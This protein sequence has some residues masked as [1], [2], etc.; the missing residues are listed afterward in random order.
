VRH[1]HWTSGYA[2]PANRGPAK[3]TV[4][5]KPGTVLSPDAGVAGG[6]RSLSP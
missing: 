6:T 5:V 4:S 3:R 2:A 1:V